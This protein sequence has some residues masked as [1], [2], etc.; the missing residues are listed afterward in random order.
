VEHRGKHAEHRAEH[1]EH[2]AEHA[3]HHCYPAIPD[4]DMIGI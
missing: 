2:R 4:S 1:A 3:E